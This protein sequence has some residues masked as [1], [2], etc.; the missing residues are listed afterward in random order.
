MLSAESLAE[1]AQIEYRRDSDFREY[2]DDQ[3]QQLQ[4]SGSVQIGSP[5]TEVLKMPGPGGIPLAKLW[6]S[7]FHSQTGQ[8]Q[9]QRARSTSAGA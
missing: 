9:W 7:G 6:L 4:A 8:P 3:L 2:V 1:F 5:L